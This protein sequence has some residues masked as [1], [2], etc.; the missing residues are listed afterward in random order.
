MK[1][2]FLG[3]GNMGA[4]MARNLVKAG[5]QVT[6]WN[7]T[8]KRA[9]VVS[10]GA[11]ANTPAE[12]AKNAEVALTMLA[13]DQAAEV[14]VFGE[15][16][17]LEGLP[18]GS[19]HISS[20]TIGVELSRR[21]WKAHEEQGQH[22]VAA[23]VF[24]RPEAAEAAKLFIVTAGTPD[25]VRKCEPLLSAIGQKTFVMGT[26]PPLANVVKVSGNFLIASI[27]ESLGEAVA[28]TMGWIRRLSW[29]S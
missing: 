17:L 14:V 4:P 9:M 28:L 24:G 3:L 25:V 23:P 10:G 1:V 15:N 16:G 22:Y 29:T 12:A 19:I 27:I 26:E 7:R 6:V 11:A 21:I 13:D 5:H 8:R 2:A 20:S 18:K